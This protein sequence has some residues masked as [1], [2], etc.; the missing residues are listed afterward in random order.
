MHNVVH[1]FSFPSFI[2]SISNW[3]LGKVEMTTSDTQI[4][5]ACICLGRA[6]TTCKSI[7]VRWGRF[8]T[9]R[10][11]HSYSGGIKHSP[12]QR[13]LG[14]TLYPPPTHYHMH[15]TL[16][17][18]SSGLFA[19]PASSGSES[20]FSLPR[21]ESPK[22]KRVILKSSSSCSIYLGRYCRGR[23]PALELSLESRHSLFQ[24]LPTTATAAF[25]P[26]SFS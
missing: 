16:A 6:K 12:R 15:G 26:R 25:F 19:R 24:E 3:T 4:I 11:S 23:P 22:S 9:F 14:L 18:G 5:R 20:S 1:P 8:N 10:D 2:I 17:P 21:G 13:K 7:G